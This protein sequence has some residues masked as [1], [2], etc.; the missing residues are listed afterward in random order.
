MKFSKVQLDSESDEI[1]FDNFTITPNNLIG[2]K[3]FPVVDARIPHVSLKTESLTSLQSTGNIMIQQLLLSR[4]EIALYVDQEDAEKSND[5]Q[6]EQ[7]VQKVIE[8]L[9]IAD[10]KIDGGSLILKEKKNEKEIN[11]FK[12]LSITLSD[13]DFDL[14]STNSLSKNFYL[15]KDFQFELSDYEVK[16]PDSLNILKIG[17][18]LLSKDYLKLKD[19]ALIPRYGDYEYT[20]KVG[21]QTDVAKVNISEIV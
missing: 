10:F 20:R 8:N 18:A 12:N 21:F 1:T 17:L 5:D 3:G 7:A 6:A 16:L 4:P 11:S 19:V 2:K 13:L 14:S 15:N 9:K